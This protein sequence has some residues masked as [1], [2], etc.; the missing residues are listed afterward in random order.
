MRD[1]LRRHH[2]DIAIFRILNCVFQEWDKAM[3]GLRRPPMPVRVDSPSFGLR[4]NPSGLFKIKDLA[5]VA[6]RLLTSPRLYGHAM[7]TD[8]SARGLVGAQV[9]GAVGSGLKCSFEL[10]VLLP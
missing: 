8:A 9:S 6:E 2:T 4:D 7:M 1:R 5:R 10:I 3:D